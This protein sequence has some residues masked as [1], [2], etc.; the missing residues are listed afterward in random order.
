MKKTI[1]LIIAAIALGN[2]LSAKIVR[3]YESHTTSDGLMIE[4]DSIDYRKEVTRV[5]GRLTGRPHTSG[6][7]DGATLDGIQCSDMEGVDFNRYFQWEEDGQIPVELDFPPVKTKKNVN[8]A[9][10]IIELYTPR[11]KSQISFNKTP[12]K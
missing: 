11:G 6:R 9:G 10:G 12:K 2:S 4:V 8:K 5:Y 7:I 3:G 1:T